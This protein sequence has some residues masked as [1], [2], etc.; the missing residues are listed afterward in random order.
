MCIKSLCGCLSS[1]Q[2][3]LLYR[4]VLKT[5]EGFFGLWGSFRERSTLLFQTGRP[6]HSF[7]CSH[8]QVPQK[9]VWSHANVGLGK[10]TQ[11]PFVRFVRLSLGLRSTEYS[12]HFDVMDALERSIIFLF[13]VLSLQRARPQAQHSRLLKRLPFYTKRNDTFMLAGVESSL[14][15]H[16]R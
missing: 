6:L 9:T 4:S 13:R 1:V 2:E 15:Y 3:H 11:T 14:L 7:M 8:Y 12:S 16:S 10:W 5:H